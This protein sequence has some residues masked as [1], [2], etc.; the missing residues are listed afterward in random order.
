MVVPSQIALWKRPTLAVGLAIVGLMIV[1]GS[2][3]GESGGTNATPADQ[4]AQAPDPAAPQVDEADSTSPPGNGPTGTVT[5]GDQTWEFDSSQCSVYAEDVVS[6]S[7]SAIA[8]PAVEIVF[9]V[10]GPGEHELRV[11]VDGASWTGTSESISA[12]VDGNDVTGGGT[13]VYGLESAD[14]TFEFHCQ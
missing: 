10:F 5:I 8:D 14:A 4:E 12:T 11:D 2:C 13:V 6:I 7:G 9:D 3:G 1:A